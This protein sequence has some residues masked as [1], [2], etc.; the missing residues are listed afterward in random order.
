MTK[1]K[2]PGTSLFTSLVCTIGIVLSACGGS[3]G[4]TPVEQVIAPAITTQPDSQSVVA[5]QTATFSVTATGSTLS[6]QWKKNG[7]TIDG[8]T[9]STYTTPPTT[10]ADNNTAFS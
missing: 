1:L 4:T 10:N 5:G 2:L 9:S 3:G 6:Y 8:A 7:T